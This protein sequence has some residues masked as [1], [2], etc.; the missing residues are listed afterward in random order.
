ME[1]QIESYNQELVVEVCVR[2]R[3][4]HGFYEDGVLFFADNKTRDL[5]MHILA[6]ELYSNDVI[7]RLNEVCMMGSKGQMLGYC[8]TWKAELI[9]LKHE[10]SAPY[11]SKDKG[12]E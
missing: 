4:E 7:G 3:I 12:A 11:W 10:Q 5:V 6:I 2:F 1:N 9:R 8:R